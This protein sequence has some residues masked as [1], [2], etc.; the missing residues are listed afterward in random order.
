[1]PSR[2]LIV[3][4]DDEIARE[5]VSASAQRAG[6][7]CVGYSSAAE[8]REETKLHDYDMLVLDLNLLDT[9]GIEVLQ[10]LSGQE[11]Q[12][13]IL[14]VSSLEERVLYSTLRVGSSMG[15]QLLD[16]VR[17]PLRP[18]ELGNILASISSTKAPLRQEDLKAGLDASQFR[19]AYQPKVSLHDGRV[20][21]AEALARWTH[22]ERG[23]I[24]P[25]DFI[26]L[27]EDGPLIADLTYFVART[28]IEDCK[29]WSNEGFHMSVAVNVSA[30]SLTDRSFSD[31]LADLVRESS[32][33]ADQ[34]TLE[35]TETS[36]MSDASAM[37]AM[38]TQLRIRGFNLSMDDF[39][40]GYS[41]LMQLHRLPFSEVKI[42]RSFIHGMDTDQEA[43]VIS[44]AMIG[45]GHNLGMRVVAEGIETKGVMQMLQEEGCDIGQGYYLGK[46]MW[47]N[48]FLD[49]LGDSAVAVPAE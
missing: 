49:W 34:I 48:E 6:F 37:L 15:L 40:T 2:K 27:A 20:I 5:I 24:S 10:Y 44:R 7:S 23:P 8:L 42:D 1:M 32:L 36:A 30:K 29:T 11:F 22:P 4:D 21:G 25:G 14:L 33:Q 46:P 41:S 12:A 31:K 35:I 28:S 3:L 13:P 43:R 16:P 17:K 18:S 9:D 26:A 19:V 39:G 47:H 45:L 38:L